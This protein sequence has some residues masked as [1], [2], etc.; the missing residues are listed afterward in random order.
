MLNVRA[1]HTIAH[2]E[3]SP[4]LLLSSLFNLV[5]ADYVAGSAKNA[6]EALL[7]EVMLV[8]K[9]KRRL[10]ATL[11]W[12]LDPAHDYPQVDAFQLLRY[13]TFYDLSTIRV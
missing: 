6:A 11:R 3:R 7:E 5:W 10:E 12:I 8:L 1:R 2:M 4:Q 9:D 13:S